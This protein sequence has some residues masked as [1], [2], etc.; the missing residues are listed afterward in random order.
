MR[1]TPILLSGLI[2]LLVSGCQDKK[3]DVDLFTEGPVRVSLSSSIRRGYEP[4]LVEFSAYLET[5]ESVFSDEISEAKWI[6]RGPNRSE[7]EIMH[8]ARNYQYEEDNEEDFFYLEHL[9]RTPGRY[10][11][12]L[13]LNQG[14]YKSN[15]LPID[16][17]KK[18]Q[19]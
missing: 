14:Q 3:S 7:Q 18:P 13:V 4:L 8:S 15:W 6:I 10:R 1:Y 16:V 9:F 19:Q 2:L 5:D 17:W 12:Q 11:V